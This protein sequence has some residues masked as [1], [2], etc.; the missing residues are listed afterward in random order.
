[1][2][3]AQKKILLEEWNEYWKEYVKNNPDAD[4]SDYADEKEAF[5]EGTN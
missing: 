5:F 4:G 2:S 3:E 1:M